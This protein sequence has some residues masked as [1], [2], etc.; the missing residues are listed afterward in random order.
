MDEPTS[1]PDT[2]S[3]RPSLITPMVIVVLGVVLDQVTKWWALREL[4]D[5]SVIE[6]VPTLEFDLA[7]NS[8]FSFGTGEGLGRWIGVLVIALCLFLV[9]QIR[10]SETALRANIAAIVLGGAI[11]NLLDRIFRAEDGPLSGEVIDF[12]DVTWYAVFNVADIFVVCGCIT[13][14]FHEIQLARRRD[15]DPD[16]APTAEPEGEPA[17]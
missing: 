13:F 3:S 15:D 8:G 12:I 4:E 2:G 5:G 17:T 7:Y 14:G 16:P 10:V 9:H 1:T 6:L 11:G